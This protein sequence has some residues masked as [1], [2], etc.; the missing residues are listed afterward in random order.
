LLHTYRATFNK[1]FRTF[2]ILEDANFRSCTLIISARFDS[3]AIVTIP[4]K[5]IVTDTK[6]IGNSFVENTLCVRTTIL[7]NVTRYCKTTNVYLQV[8]GYIH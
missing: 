2:T 1:S 3:E 4:F 6:V 5:S 7:S 8:L